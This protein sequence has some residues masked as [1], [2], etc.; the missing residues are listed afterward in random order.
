M[1]AVQRL[2]TVVIVGLVALSTMLVLYLADE[3][4]RIAKGESEQQTASIERATNTYILQC[5]RCH[6]PAGLGVTGPDAKD[7]NGNPTGRVGGVIGGVNATLN[8][9]GSN[10]KGT[11]YA[12]GNENGVTFAAGFTGRTEWI[13][14]R[15]TNGLWDAKNQKYRMPPF[16][17]SRGGPLNSEQINEL[18]TMIQHGDWNEVYN[19][20]IAASGGQYPTPPPAALSSPPV[21][22][23]PPAQGTPATG[24]AT[25]IEIDMDD[26]KFDQTE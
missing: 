13:H 19:Q 9:T 24:P 17:D 15:I 10:D 11:P 14:N 8:H 26:I 21:V 7:A 12:G 2:A 25:A 20:S 22:G 1:G 23:S 3:N 5:L 4:N 6:G 18:V 16:A